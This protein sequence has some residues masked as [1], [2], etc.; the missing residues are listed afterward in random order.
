MLPAGQGGYGVA[1]H[2]GGNVSAHAVVPGAAVRVELGWVGNGVAAGAQVGGHGVEGGK[3]E[4]GQACHWSAEVDP[5]HGE[6]LPGHARGVELGGNDLN[7]LKLSANPAGGCMA[8]INK[9]GLRRNVSAAVKREI[10]RRCGFGCVICG[11]AYYDYEHFDP[12]FSEA[13]GHNPDG[14][15]LLCPNHNQ[16]KGRS[17]LSAETVA[18]ANANPKC[19]QSGFSSATYDF[20]VDPI[21]IQFAGITITNCPVLL[22]VRGID[23]LS[24]LPPEEP[25]APIR[26]SG[27]FSDRTGATTLK[28]VD[29]E[30]L[31]GCDNWD[32][33][34]VGPVTTIRRGLGDIALQIRVDPPRRLI[35]ERLDM[36]IDGYLLKG[37]KDQLFT[38]PNGVDWFV[39]T[40]CAAGD[41]PVGIEFR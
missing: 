2:Q 38:S 21:E 12:D 34:S 28:I 25:G 9:H 32:V 19:L 11:L 39:F 20:G 37:S 31:A 40:S 13:K 6:S 7:R 36:N 15:T 14:M 22:R 41:S 24:V 23:V 35:I 1:V 27:I 18:R 16:G 30:W 26:L 10:R 8:Q 4:A 17:R 33:E 29:N 5:F 3:V